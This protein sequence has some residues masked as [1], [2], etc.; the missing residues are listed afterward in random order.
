[1]AVALEAA[2]GPVA[3]CLAL[4][5]SAEGMKARGAADD[6]AVAA[7]LAAHRVAGEP[8]VAYYTALGKARTIDATGDDDATYDAAVKALAE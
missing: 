1:M 2:V 7:A 5:G 6:A 3:C 4:R 8:V